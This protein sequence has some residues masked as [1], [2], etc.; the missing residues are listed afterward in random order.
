MNTSLV[1]IHPCNF[2]EAIEMENY[3][4]LYDKS[5]MTRWEK[6]R[7]STQEDIVESF[8]HDIK[9]QDSLQSFQ[10]SHNFDH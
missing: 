9:V 1:P 10:Y 8:V 7:S 5:L 3:I 2:T 4:A 6:I